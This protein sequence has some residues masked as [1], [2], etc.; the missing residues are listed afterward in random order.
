M[1]KD[2]KQAVS[3]YV[4]GHAKKSLGD[5]AGGDADIA[6]AKGLNANIENNFKVAHLSD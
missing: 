3:L 5:S 6:A 2:P 4:R 1:A